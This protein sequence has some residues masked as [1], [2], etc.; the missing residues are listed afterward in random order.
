[1]ETPNALGVELVF[2]QIFDFQSDMCMVSGPAAL[3]GNQKLRRS[4]LEEALLAE[5]S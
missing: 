2:Y 5:H 1:V 3:E 4:E